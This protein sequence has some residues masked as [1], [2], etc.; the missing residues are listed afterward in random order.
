[1][2]VKQSICHFHTIQE[3]DQTTKVLLAKNGESNGFIR[4]DVERSLYSM[5]EKVTPQRAMMA[6]IAGGSRSENIT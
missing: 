2:P 5:V 6:L 1:M 3:L 4:D